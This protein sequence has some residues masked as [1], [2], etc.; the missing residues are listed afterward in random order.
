MP[1]LVGCGVLFLNMGSGNPNLS[2]QGLGNKDFANE[3][4]P[5]LVH[6]QVG[7]LSLPP[8]QRLFMYTCGG[9]HEMGMEDK[10]VFKLR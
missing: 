7:S 1:V 4:L 8:I 10:L 6:A 9:V 5:V 2:V 3:A